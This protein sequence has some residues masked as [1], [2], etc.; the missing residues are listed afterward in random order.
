MT[1]KEALNI[2]YNIACIDADYQQKEYITYA[3]EIEHN[4]LVKKYF[5][6]VSQALDDL[7]VLEKENQELKEEINELSKDK[8]C[9]EKRCDKFEKVLEILK[10]HLDLGVYIQQ[11]EYILCAND[12][13]IPSLDKE[14]GELLSEVLGE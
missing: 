11:G 13:A 3:K 1:S 9:F 10:G 12:Y 6:I 8:T 7:E 4:E 14:K 2:L 5:D